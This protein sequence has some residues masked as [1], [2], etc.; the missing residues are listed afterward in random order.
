[1]NFNFD[2]NFTSMF[3]TL[4]TMYKSSYDLGLYTK[5]QIAGFVRNGSLDEDGYKRI[6]GD[7]YE[8][9]TENTMVPPEA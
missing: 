2:F 6:T 1:M 3:N 4:E 8:S 7:D 5:K 9:R